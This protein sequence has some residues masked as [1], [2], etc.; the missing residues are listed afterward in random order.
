[1]HAL[2]GRLLNSKN[3][4]RKISFEGQSTLPF[5]EWENEQPAQPA[6]ASKRRNVYA[7][8]E[9]P[10]PKRKA[11]DPSDRLLKY[12]SLG[13]GSSGN[14]CYIGTNAGGII[15]DAGIKADVIES[16]LKANGV[17]MQKVKGIL[18]THDHSDHVRYVYTLVR[19]H[20]HLK[21]YC[22]LRVLNAILRRHGI[23]KRLKEYH[24]PIFKEIPFN[25]GDFEI[26]AFDV[27]HDASDNAGFHFRAPSGK[28]FVMATDLG[29]VTPRAH[30]YMEQADYLMIEANYDA[31]MLRLGPY[32]EYL[33]VRIATDHGHLDNRDTARLLSEIAGGRLKHV[34]LCH[35]SKDNNTPEKALE[36]TRKALTDK[37]LTVGNGEETLEDRAADIQLQALPR[38]QPTRWYVFH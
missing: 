3:L 15:I 16:T 36:A 22:T 34:F 28:T 18:L 37:G 1:M 10:Q 9:I 26:T 29:A 38:F 19:A 33:K 31:T 24:V 14:S 7:A 2:E 25:I 35:L 21:V 6:P 12:M 23:A 11:V 4:A 30:H 5:E 32:P 20:K 8:S 13:S 17:D 27:P